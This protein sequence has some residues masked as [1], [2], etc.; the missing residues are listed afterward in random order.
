MG[1]LSLHRIAQGAVAL[2]VVIVLRSLG[3][4]LRIDPCGATG[5]TSEGRLYV[6]GAM[7]AAASALVTLALHAM[8]RNRTAIAMTAVT[9][10]A[11]LTY[12]IVAL[13]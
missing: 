3:E 8:D 5:L 11:L 9:I 6:V 1:R 10:L 13:V 7:A 12:K 4:L 2:L